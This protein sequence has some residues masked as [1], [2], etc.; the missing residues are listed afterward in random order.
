MTLHFDFYKVKLYVY[1]ITISIPFDSSNAWI[2]ENRTLV[3]D[4][5]FGK[6]KEVTMYGE[7]II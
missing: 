2:G 6:K 3:V 5:F 1:I 4:V 7:E